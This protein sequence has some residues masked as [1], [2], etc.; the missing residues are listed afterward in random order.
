MKGSPRRQAMD[1][2]A[3]LGH[4][5]ELIRRGDA[6]QVREWGLHIPRNWARA[7]AL[8]RELFVQSCTARDGARFAKTLEVLIESCPDARVRIFGVLPSQER[9]VQNAA[10]QGPTV[11]SRLHGVFGIGREYFAEDRY[12]RLEALAADSKTLL[13]NPARLQSLEWV[14]STFG[15]PR[16]PKITGI[17]EGCR[18]DCLALN[19]R[20]GSILEKVPEAASD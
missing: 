18:A 15:L 5:I 14:M 10:S 6:A 11:L 19:A 2:S 9:M 7:P 4:V 3:A 17:L 12:A 1:H 20:L 8:A 16:T 13:S